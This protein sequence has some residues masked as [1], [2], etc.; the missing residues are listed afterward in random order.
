MQGSPQICSA[1]MHRRLSRSQ[2]P[3]RGMQGPPWRR[4][5]QACKG[6]QPAI[7]AVKLPRSRRTRRQRSSRSAG[8]RGRLGADLPG[9]LPS[10]G[11]HPSRLSCSDPRCIS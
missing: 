4:A 10:P 7:E 9:P 8:L 11:D 2:R 5:L 3:H 6:L 1:A